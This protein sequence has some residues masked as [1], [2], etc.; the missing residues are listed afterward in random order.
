MKST[1]GSYLMATLRDLDP[2]PFETWPAGQLPVTAPDDRWVVLV[3]PDGPAGAVAPGTTLAEGAP[4]G[5]LVAVA[6]L[7]QAEAFTSA[8]F[9]EF[10]QVNALVLTEPGVAAGD[11]PAIAGVVSDLRLER[12]LLRGPVRGGTGPALPGVPLVPLICR[13]CGYLEG[14]VA[15]ATPLSFRQR[16]SQ[17]PR[18]PNDRALAAHPFTW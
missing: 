13:S 1:K 15:C 10:M 4:S 3:G 2:E 12:A 8:A 16:P 5:I 7:D 18:C 14:R 9:Q 17:M 11:E 6:D